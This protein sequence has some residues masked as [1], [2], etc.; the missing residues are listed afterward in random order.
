[1][2]KILAAIFF[3]I[4]LLLNA[5]YENENSVTIN[6]IEYYM[7]TDIECYVPGDS[8]HMIYR[9]KNYSSS[10]I[11]FLFY[12]AQRYDFIVN[13]EE[14]II[15]YWS[16]LMIFAQYLWW[17]TLNPGDSTEALYSWDITDNWGDQISPG[18]YEVSGFYTYENYDTVPVSVNIEYL[19]V[20]I[21]DESL[22][23]LQ[24]KLFNFPNPFNPSTTILYSLSTDFNNPQI[25]IFNTRGQK[26]KNFQ[27]EEKSGQN[28]IIWN[29]E[30]ENNK[31]VSTGIYLYKL[32]ENENSSFVKKCLLIK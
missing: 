32:S 12:T 28:S 2:N 25:E 13:Q 15:W 19:P 3:I 27:L 31:S 22:C 5:Q 26:I 20:D 17:L 29:G 9:I 30:D 23:S 18:I 21:N 1:M 14:N 24:I 6:D 11:S 7:A 16:F 10:A 8:V 4:P